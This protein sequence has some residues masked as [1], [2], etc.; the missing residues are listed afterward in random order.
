[1]V[2]FSR[3]EYEAGHKATGGYPL[4]AA[5][6]PKLKNNESRFGMSFHVAREFE[7]AINRPLLMNGC[8]RAARYNRLPAVRECPQPATRVCR[9]SSQGPLQRSGALGLLFCGSGF[10]P[11][12]L[13]STRIVGQ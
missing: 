8:S 7:P 3:A 13:M 6:R 4:N 9:Q 2:N 5:S 1:M 12:G 11:S 10:P